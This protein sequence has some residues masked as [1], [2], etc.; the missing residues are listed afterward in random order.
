MT[1][2][3]IVVVA[4]RCET[5]LDS[6]LVHRLARLDRYDRLARNTHAQS[7]SRA[8]EYPEICK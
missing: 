4:F 1:V 3:N 6:S 2:P 5:V 7:M 8:E